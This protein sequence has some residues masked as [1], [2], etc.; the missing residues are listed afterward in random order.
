VAAAAAIGELMAQ[1][2]KEADPA[3]YLRLYKQQRDPLAREVLAERVAEWE[4]GAGHAA[5]VPL[6][7]CLRY[8]STTGQREHQA[9]WRLVYWRAA[10]ETRAAWRCLRCYPELERITT[11]RVVEEREAQHAQA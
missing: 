1:P 4:R 5:G 7:T 6:L 9:H 2:A 11:A 8:P 10:G 3:E